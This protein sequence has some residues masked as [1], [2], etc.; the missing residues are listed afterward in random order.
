MQSPSQCPIPLSNLL[1]EANDEN[2][3]PILPLY[4]V[5]KLT[6]ENVSLEILRNITTLQN[7]IATMY[8]TK[9]P[10]YPLHNDGTTLQN[11]IATMD[12]TKCPNYPL[13]NDGT[14][15]KYFSLITFTEI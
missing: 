2:A 13:H 15:D 5:D 4:E 10:N 14:I 9:C 3:L 1:I 7:F 8:N 6:N 12:N 11:V